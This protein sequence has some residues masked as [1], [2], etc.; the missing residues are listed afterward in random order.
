MSNFNQHR[1][2]GANGRV[3]RGKY[4]HSCGPA[5]PNGTP[6]WWRRLFMTRPRRHANTA[7]CARIVKGDEPGRMSFSLGSRKP[8]LYYW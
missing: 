3:L 8:H 1:D 2:R 4:R 5:F 6:K 7:C